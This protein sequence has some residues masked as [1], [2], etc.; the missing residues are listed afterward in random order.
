MPFI[1]LLILMLIFSS[2]TPLC[3]SA[4][5]FET[6]SIHLSNN[7]PITN[8][9]SLA[10]PDIIPNKALASLSFSTQLEL[11][12]YISS[13]IKTRDEFYIDGETWTYRNSL[14]YQLKSNLIIS[15]SIPWVKHSG[16][17]SDSFIYNFHDIFQL[18]Q[19]GRRQ[20][21][22]DKI[23]WILNRDGK[24]LV[25]IDDDLSAWGD[26]SITAQL[27]PE[28]SPS[29]RWTFMTKLPTG[30]YKKQSGSNEFDLGVSFAQINPDWF[31]ERSVLSDWMLSIWY[32]TGLS[33]LG[34]VDELRA[35][36]QNPL[37]MSFRTGIAYAYIPTWH[38]KCQFDAHTALF[39]SEIRELGWM[40]LQISLSTMHQLSKQTRFE[41]AIIED[42]RPRSAPDVIFQTTFETRF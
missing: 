25:N 35:L 42:I 16:G 15:A 13:T 37:V 6:N 20:N 18:P 27:T 2:N 22:E 11:T 12:N 8:L 23:R 4:N 34:E 41:F 14:H 5:Y 24:T 3:Y 21:N 29:V 28:H 38:L 10:R 36:E 26:L 17:I 1:K 31:K 32:G 33:Y 40:P 30:D 19:N 39:D 9:F 7:G